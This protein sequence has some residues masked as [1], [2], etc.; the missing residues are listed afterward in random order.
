MVT[1]EINNSLIDEAIRHSKERLQYEFNRFGLPTPQRKSMI[2]IGTIGQLIFKEYLEEKGVEFDFEYQAGEYDIMDFS[3]NNEIVEIKT[4]GYGPRGYNHL[5]IFYAED[6]FQAGIVKG[7]K[8][9]VQ[10]FI[11]G[12]IRKDKLL[13]PSNCNSATI[14][15]FTLFE[16]IKKYPN[17]RVFFGDDYKVPINDLIPIEQLINN[18]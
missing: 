4:S 14:A 13:V 10:I 15:G 6:Q 3:I 9:C 2:L 5:N 16:D 12:Y 1:R 7:F 18:D 17:Q 11:N 8:Y